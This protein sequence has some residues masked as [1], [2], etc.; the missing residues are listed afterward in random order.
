MQASRGFLGDPGPRD[1]QNITCLEYF[2]KKT[3]ASIQG[4]YKGNG[5]CAAP[6]AQAYHELMGHRVPRAF[7]LPARRD[8]I[9][10]GICPR[11]VLYRHEP[12]K[13]EK[14]R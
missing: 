3:Y 10:T 6:T 12:N 2:P 14:G 5:V 7:D 9:L 1:L 11:P 4:L 13:N 8:Q